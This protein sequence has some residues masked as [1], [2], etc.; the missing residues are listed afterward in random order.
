MLL[1]IRN[2]SIRPGVVVV[3]SSE[4][5][6]R[7]VVTSECVPSRDKPVFLSNL[8]TTLI[9]SI[10]ACAHSQE[11]LA[12]SHLYGRSGHL[13]IRIFIRSTIENSK[14]IIYI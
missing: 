3:N 13:E 11:V 1:F 7:Y 12:A 4:V 14:T 6:I 2:F 10:L 8:N 9:F 5:T